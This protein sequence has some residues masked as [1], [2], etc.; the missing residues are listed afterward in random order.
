MRHHVIEEIIFTV[1]HHENLKSCLHS[2]SYWY[3]NAVH[4]S[5]GKITDWILSVVNI[6]KRQC[7]SPGSFLQQKS[8]IVHL[9]F[10]VVK[11]TLQYLSFLPNY[12]EFT[13]PVIIPLIR[14]IRQSSCYWY[15]YYLNVCDGPAWPVHY[16]N[17]TPGWT[18]L[19][20]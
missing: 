16:Q 3:V 15:E 18:S 4:K 13:L 8:V 9:G 2:F 19:L 10:V 20:K 11:V 5:T 6:L 17:L 1:H 14:I 7:H 12:F